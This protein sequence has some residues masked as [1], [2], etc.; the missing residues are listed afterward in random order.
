M[1]DGEGAARSYTSRGCA[2]HAV[3]SPE[4]ER[5]HRRRQLPGLIQWDHLIIGNGK[6]HWV[7]L[8]QRGVL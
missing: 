5:S 8:A 3:H 7:S 1:R 6:L 2:V 4:A